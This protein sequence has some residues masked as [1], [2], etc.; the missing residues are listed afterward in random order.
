MPKN[1]LKKTR[2]FE[3]PNSV[4]GWWYAKFKIRIPEN[5]VPLSHIDLLIAHEVVNPALLKYN[6]NIKLWRIHRR[7][8]NDKT[9]HEFSFI[10]YC[11]LDIATSVYNEFRANTL[12]QS[13]RRNKVLERVRYDRTNKIRKPNLEDTNDPIWTGLIQKRWMYYIM[14]V[15]EL[16]LGLISDIVNEVDIEQKS[17]K[18]AETIEFYKEIGKKL[19]AL[20]QMQCRHPLLHHMNAIF[21]YEPIL[22]I[23][24]YV[25]QYVVF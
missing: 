14:S 20:W 24:N 19:N 21:G 16:W 22:I 23:P 6:N 8:N 10:F 11:R 13:L 12:I 3:N 15:S 5:G 25:Q 4:N 7:W 17:K 2:D 9:G 1:S 18:I